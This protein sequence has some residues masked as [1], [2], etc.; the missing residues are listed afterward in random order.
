MQLLYET[1]V[2]MAENGK[3]HLDFDDLPFEKGTRFTVKLIPDEL[4]SQQIYLYHL[5]KLQEA[6]IARDPF[7]GMTPEQ[8]VAEL[9][10]QREEMYDGE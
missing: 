6:F 3:L 4:T 9:R 7:P 2:Q 10:R 1:H 8:I 5:K